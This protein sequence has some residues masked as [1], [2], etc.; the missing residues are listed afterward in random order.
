M[1]QVSKGGLKEAGSFKVP[2]AP[3]EKHWSPLSLA[4]GV[5]YVR[6]KN[7]LFALQVR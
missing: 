7:Q 1:V 5:L 4:D 2:G 6:Q 3:K